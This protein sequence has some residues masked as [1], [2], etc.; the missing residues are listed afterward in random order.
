MR[1]QLIADL[2]EK[3]DII[4]R[5]LNSY[6]ESPRTY[7]TGTD[8]ITLIEMRMVYVV[9]C[10]PG[11]GNRELAAHLQRTKST[12]S[13]MTNSMA[14]RGYINKEQSGTDSRKCILT[15][16]P[17]GEELFRYRSSRIE[18]YFSDL[19][20]ELE[21]YDD[22]ELSRSIEIIDDLLRTCRETSDS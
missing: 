22:R 15:L 6:K 8:K 9:G 5:N 3:I 7:G 12:V 1:K 4:S 17:K 19:E 11:I 13:I 2:V 10:H 14:D 16:S 20:K 18:N 21:K